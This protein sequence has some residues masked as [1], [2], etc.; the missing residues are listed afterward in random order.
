M[1]GGRSMRCTTIRAGD[2]VDGNGKKVN[3]QIY[4]L[5]TVSSSASSSC[6]VDPLSPLGLLLLA[7]F[8]SSFQSYSISFQLAPAATVLL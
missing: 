5:H 4:F 1:G 8:F 6:C 3:H 7:T 2:G